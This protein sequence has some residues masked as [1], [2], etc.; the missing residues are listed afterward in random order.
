[1]RASSRARGARTKSSFIDEWM[2]KPR[3]EDL[4]VPGAGQPTSWVAHAIVSHPYQHSGLSVF[5]FFLVLI[6]PIF[7][8]VKWY[9]F[10]ALIVLPWKWNIHL[11]HE[12]TYFTS[13]Y[14]PKRNGKYIQTC[15]R[16]SIA[17]LFIQ[18]S[19]K[20]E[21]IKCPSVGEWI[22]K[23]W[24]I[25]TMEYHPAWKM[26]HMTIIYSMMNPKYIMLS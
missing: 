2:L 15:V 11:T 21:R 6:I 5:F 16:L 23:L 17:T 7:L 26:E 18:S 20:L 25:P 22:N 9:L 12:P 8:G 3:T 4:T 13:E 19:P 24:Y 10:V 1:M 14:L